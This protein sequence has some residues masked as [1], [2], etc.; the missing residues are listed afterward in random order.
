MLPP[1]YLGSQR[2]SLATV[3]VIDAFLA[4]DGEDPYFYPGPWLVEPHGSELYY[5]IIFV[6]K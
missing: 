1:S 6:W 4:L 5:H 2:L 3:T